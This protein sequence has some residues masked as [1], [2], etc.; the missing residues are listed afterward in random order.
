VSV[1]LLFVPLYGLVAIR[2]A[3]SIY[4]RFSPEE[5][6]ARIVA[7]TAVSLAIGLLGIQVLGLW[8]AVWETIRV[9][10]GHIGTGIRSA[11]AANWTPELRGQLLM[12]AIALFWLIASFRHRLD[13]KARQREALSAPR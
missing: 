13:S 4:R 12:I 7:L 8:G 2:A 9:G 1:A 3:M 10:N 5:R 11:A 6:G